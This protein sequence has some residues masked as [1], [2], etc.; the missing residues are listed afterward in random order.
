MKML[1][2]ARERAGCIGESHKVR[3]MKGIIDV[4]LLRNEFVKE[5]KRKRTPRAHD[6]DS[7]TL[8]IDCKIVS[9]IAD[10]DLI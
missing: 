6:V 4:N 7:V 9:K 5:A 10:K 1:E 2:V 8:K 3:C